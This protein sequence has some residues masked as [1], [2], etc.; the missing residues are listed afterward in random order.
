MKSG[1]WGLKLP[2]HLCHLKL[3]FLI[4]ISGFITPGQSWKTPQI[5]S[6]PPR[7]K[8]WFLE[9]KPWEANILNGRGH[10]EQ[11]VW[12]GS[13][14]SRGL[15]G[16]SEHTPRGS[17]NQPVS[18]VR[19][20]WEIDIFVIDSPKIKCRIATDHLGIIPHVLKIFGF[21]PKET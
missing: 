1:S 21:L 18:S 2:R 6:R 16:N 3:K 5:W 11:C 15:P 12:Q 13:W 8:W 20:T 7:R 4:H 19:A 14:S 17:V 9:E 10:S